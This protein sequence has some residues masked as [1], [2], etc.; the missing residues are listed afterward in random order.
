MLKLV[1]AIRHCSGSDDSTI[2]L[3]DVSTGACLETWQKDTSQV[4]CLAFS[5]QGNTLASGGVSSIM[6][7]WDISTSKCLRMLEGHSNW[8]FSVAFSPNGQVATGSVDQTIKLWDIN[9]GQLR[10]RAQRY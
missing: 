2:K 9:T 5:L 10:D 4:R 7:L 1:S 3:W 8:I 6:K